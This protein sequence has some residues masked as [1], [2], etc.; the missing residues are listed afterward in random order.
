VVVGVQVLV[1]AVPELVEAEL[2][3]VAE[4]EVPAPSVAAVIVEFLPK[5]YCMV[6]EHRIDNPCH[7]I[8]NLRNKLEKGHFLPK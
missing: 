8:Q 1:E 3:V 5:N 2:V 7:L 4:V 6:L